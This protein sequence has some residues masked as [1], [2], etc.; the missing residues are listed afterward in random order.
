MRKSAILILTSMSLAGCATTGSENDITPCTGVDCPNSDGSTQPAKCASYSP[1]R[2]AYFGDLHSH[3]GFSFDARSYDTVVTPADAYAFAKGAPTTLAPLDDKGVGTREVTLDRPL[4]FVAITDHGEFLGEIYTCTTP[5]APG[6]DSKACQAYRIPDSEGAFDFGVMLAVDEPERNLAYCGGDIAN[7]TA[8]A[9]IRWQ[10]MQ[11]AANGAY[12]RCQ[13]TAFVAYEY[14]NTIAVSNLHRNVIFRTDVVPELPVT[15]FEAPSP[16]TL[17]EKLDQQCIQAETGCD[18]IVIPHN[19]NLSNGNLFQ[20]VYPK[21]DSLAKEAKLAAF[22][23]R[24]EPVVEMFQHKGDMECRNDMAFSY[25]VHDPFCD[26][27]KI[28]EEPIDDCGQEIGTGGMRLW[29]CV[30]RWDYVRNVLKLGLLEAERLGVNPYALGFIGSTDSHNGTPGHVNEVGFPGH[31]GVVDDEPAKR[32]GSGNITHDGIINNPGGLAGVWAEENTREA[33]FDAIRRKETFATSGPRI[34]IRLFGGWSYASNLCEVPD[35]LLTTAY[36]GGVPMGGQLNAPPTDAEAPVFILQA[37]WDPGTTPTPGT[38]LERLQIVKGW[39]GTD[40]KA[41]DKVFHVAGL[42]TT[43]AKVDSETCVQEGTGAETLCGVW[44]DPEFNPKQRA[45]YYARVIENPSCR[46]STRLCNA[47]S[48]E[49][50]P[51]GCQ[52]D[53][54]AKVIQERAWSSAIWWTPTS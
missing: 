30:H 32:L 11:D 13:F 33:I 40:G 3:T 15:H 38:P 35:E 18:V 22:R 9:K 10:A 5:S 34:K 28:R 48:P 41:Y 52:D 51:D 36:D 23:A 44:T 45:F 46:W 8:G 53:F 24:M 26:F 2:H 54:P 1:T 4:D 50:R 25:G 6:Y 29:G 17:W 21:V 39:V 31:V 27:E 37:E 12:D 49:E 14:T 47:M 7:C 19:S 16:W 42:Q 20:P 43:T